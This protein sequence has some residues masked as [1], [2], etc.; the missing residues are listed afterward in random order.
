[1]IQRL[2]P[3]DEQLHVELARRFK[4]HAPTLEQSRDFLADKRNWLLVAKMDNDNMAGF[5]LAYHM[6]RWDG[7]SMVFFYEIE[8]AAA[9]RTQ[10]YGRALVED[11]LRLARASGAYKMWVPTDEVNTPAMRLYESCGGTR[12]TP[13]EVTW[14]WAL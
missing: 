11:L 12:R 4:E 7:R 1:V 5:A 6:P 10:G 13:D 2:R 8:V 14:S 3:G 9:C